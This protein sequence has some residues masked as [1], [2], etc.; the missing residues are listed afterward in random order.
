MT[1][2]D[3]LIKQILAQNEL[4]QVW[5]PSDDEAP[6]EDLLPLGI[7]ADS[8]DFDV[9]RDRV[10][11]SGERFPD[12][13]ESPAILGTYQHM[14][15][16]GIITLYRR[17]I[18]GCWKSLI[19][20]AQRRFPFVTSKDAERVLDL[21]VLSVYQHE[22]FHYVCDFCRRLFGG[23]FDRLHEEA[24]A[25]AYE[26]QWLRANLGGNTFFGRMH[27]T[28]GRI[29]VRELFDQRAPGY[30]DWRNFANAAIFHDAVAAYVH[31]TGGQVFAGTSFNLG[32]W[33]VEHI[34][35]DKNKAWEEKIGT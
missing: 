13:P 24:L 32:R 14:S 34:A 18:E 16:P 26:W 22:R 31:P 12:P 28:L 27:P 35:D 2:A 23:Q 17:N 33:A 29:V 8:P 5:V 4:P 6:E 3:T 19:N 25:V 15:S 1:I 10:P 30:R 20:H 21:L 7:F 9:F 11:D